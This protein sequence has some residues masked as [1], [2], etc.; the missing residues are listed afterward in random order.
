MKTKILAALITMATMLG[1]CS[2]GDGEDGWYDR[3]P[4]GGSFVRANT[5]R[6]YYLDSDGGSLIDPDDP[7]TFPVSLGR[8]LENPLEN[9]GDFSG[10]TGFY[11]GNHNYISYDQ[12]EG[13]YYCMMSAYGDE[14]QGSFSWPVYVGG[15]TDIMEA[16]YRYTDKDVVGG[17]YWAKIISWKYNG[18][19]FYNDD[20]EHYKKVFITKSDGKTTVTL[21]RP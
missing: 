20:D 18:T 9:T 21:K 15:E 1:A 17:R 3:I 5:V 4:D 10:D 12:E 16:V 13:L 8:E 2:D 11:N 14:R 6:F 7:A 19:N